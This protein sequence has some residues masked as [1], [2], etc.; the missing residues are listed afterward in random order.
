M[1]QYKQTANKLL[2]VLNHTTQL[3]TTIDQVQ[4]SFW[5]FLPVAQKPQHHTVEVFKQVQTFFFSHYSS[6]WDS[7]AGRKYM[8]NYSLPKAA[9]A[10]NKLKS[11]TKKVLKQ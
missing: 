7:A 6:A 2:C 3:Q 5:E 10:E 4:P 8:C 1:Y 9:T 11:N